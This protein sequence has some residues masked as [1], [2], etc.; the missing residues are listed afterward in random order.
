MSSND[1]DCKSRSQ[2]STLLLP[3]FVCAAIA[4]FTLAVPKIIGKS[5]IWIFL[6]GFI[7]ESTLLLCSL[8]LTTWLT[9]G[10]LSVFGFTRGSFRLS[11]RFFLWLLPMLSIA[12]LQVV[13]SPA[14]ATASNG[15][16]SIVAIATVI[17]TIWIYVSLCEEIFTRGLLLSWLSP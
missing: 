13:L 15:Q 9:K 1:T 3:L 17:F 16:L 8:A 10:H 5:S 12:T 14:G 4:L 11:S 2:I 7:T 6:P